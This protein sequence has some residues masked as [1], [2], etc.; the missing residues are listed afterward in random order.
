MS[1][2]YWQIAA[3]S[4]GRSYSDYFI[5]FGMA[6]VGGDAQI[7]TMQQV[8]KG[9]VVIIKNGVSEI[10]AA[11]EVVER[12][13][14][15][16]GCGDKSWLRDFDGWDLEAYCYVNWHVPNKPIA[17]DGLVRSTIKRAH[18]EKH[19]KIADTILSL[20]IHACDPDPEETKV[21]NDDQILEHLI[22]EGL[23]PSSADDLT[24]TLRKIRLLAQYYYTK[25]CWED[26]REHEA[27]SF[28][29]VPLLLALGWSEQQLKIEL[30]CSYGKV[31]IACFSKAYKREKDECALIVETKDFSS[32]LDYAPDQARTY[33]DDFPSCRGVL[34]TNGY[35][36]KAYIRKEDGTF[37]MKPSAYLNLLKPRDRYPLDPVNVDGALGVLSWLLPSSLR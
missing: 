15:S 14:K 2:T 8:K 30:P 4:V 32:G 16:T 25:C 29:V 1:K 9:D 28:L 27:R 37:D 35:C 17:T 36:Y 6:F 18:Q 19:Q 34:V 7:G 24:N 26:V 33:A 21:L 10:L 13:G 12:D 23:R 22:A 3:G 11:G 20:P 5:K 31:D